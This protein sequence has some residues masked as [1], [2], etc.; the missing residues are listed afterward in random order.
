MYVVFCTCGQTKAGSGHSDGKEV[1]HRKKEDPTQP[2]NF[3]Q[4]TN[5]SPLPQIKT[6]MQAPPSPEGL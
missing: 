5:Q 1:G 2:T 3:P 4:I 6:A